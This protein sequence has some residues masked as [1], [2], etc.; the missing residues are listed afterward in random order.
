MALKDSLQLKN[1]LGC[2][3]PHPSPNQLSAQAL[4]SLSTQTNISQDLT[5]TLVEDFQTPT[6]AGH[7]SGPSVPS[8]TAGRSQN[9]DKEGSCN[10]V[11]GE[12]LCVTNAKQAQ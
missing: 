12:G 6:A 5:A 3:S 7:V 11:H 2:C 4:I 9:P 8:V 1:V 10:T